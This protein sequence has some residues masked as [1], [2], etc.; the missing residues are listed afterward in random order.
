M[1]RSYSRIDFLDGFRGVAILFIYLFHSLGISFGLDSFPWKGDFRDYHQPISFLCLSPLTLGFVGVS[2]FFAVSGFCVQLSHERSLDRSW[3]N[4]ALKRFFRIY[5]PYLFVVLLFFFFPPWGS[6]NDYSPLRLFILGTH[7]FAVHNFHPL[8][9][10]AIDGP[11]WSIAIEIQLYLL[12]PLLVLLSSKIGWRKALLI[13]AVFEIGIVLI[14]SNND[15]FFG[16]GLPHFIALSPFA[17]WLSWSLGAYLAECFLKN[18]TSRLFSI[19]VDL[20]ASIS[21]L[22]LLYKPFFPFYFLCFSWLTTVVIERFLFQKWKTP[23]KINHL[24]NPLWSH[25]TFLGISSYSFYLLHFP[26]ITLINITFVYYFSILIN[27]PL[28]KFA[29]CLGLYP[30]ILLLSYCFYR[31]VEK[32]SISLGQFIYS[33]YLCR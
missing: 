4:Y 31:L 2:I 25:L 1:N 7:I 29:I 6:L 26:I 8:T 9:S 5:P 19:R 18:K 22:V 27:S 30:L 3:I 10:V 32:K 16:M 13:P 24:L 21:I 23:E 20:L 28:L 17:Y 33:N 14:H 11:L 15:L 12:Y